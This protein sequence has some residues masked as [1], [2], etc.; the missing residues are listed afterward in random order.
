M[1]DFV[2]F[3]RPERRPHNTHIQYLQIIPTTPYD[4]EDALMY[5]HIASA[6]NTQTYQI[7]NHLHI[8]RRKRRAYSMSQTMYIR[9]HY[10]AVCIRS[11]SMWL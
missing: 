3:S 8:T 1:F 2:V 9:M 6:R 11:G 7:R 4:L 5:I 10:L